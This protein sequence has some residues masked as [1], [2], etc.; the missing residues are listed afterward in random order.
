MLSD[1]LVTPSSTVSAR[2]GWPPRA[3]ISSLACSNSKRSTSSPGRYSPSPARADL[4]LAQH[5]AN[6]HLD[7]LVV[8][9]DALRA[10]DLLHFLQQVHLAGLGTLDAQHLARVLGTLGELR[11]SLDPVAAIDAQAG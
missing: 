7:V 8:D 5:L 6:D 11:A 2:A 10:I 3:M 1:A 9:A 4:D